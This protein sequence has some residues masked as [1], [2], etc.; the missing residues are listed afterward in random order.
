MERGGGRKSLSQGSPAGQEKVLAKRPSR[1][2]HM[3][4]SHGGR[5]VHLQR[6]KVYT[7]ELKG[8]CEARMQELCLP[9]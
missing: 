5:G 4:S 7:S 8:S 2:Q 9:L 3:L 1:P 6:E